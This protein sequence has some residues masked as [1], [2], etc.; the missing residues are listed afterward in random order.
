V[1]RA[2]LVLTRREARCGIPD[3]DW[4]GVGLGEKKFN[5]WVDSG[6]IPSIVDEEASTPNRTIRYFSRLALE[7]WAMR[8]GS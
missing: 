3:T 8:N 7:A 4:S 6:R 5:Q 1:N 2:P